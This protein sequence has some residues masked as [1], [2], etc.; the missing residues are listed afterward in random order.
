MSILAAYW[1]PFS[2][3]EIIKVLMTRL[4]LLLS[5]ASAGTDIHED[6]P[7]NANYCPMFLQVNLL[8]SEECLEEITPRFK[9][10]SN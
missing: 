1:R 6:A 9:F 8:Q 5:N 7:S 10:N 4:Q 3:S 2:K